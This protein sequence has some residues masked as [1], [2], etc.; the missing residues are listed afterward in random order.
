MKRKTS[1]YTPKYQRG[2]YQ[3]TKWNS[4]PTG[5]AGG[6]ITKI[7][8]HVQ[9]GDIVSAAANTDPVLTAFTFQLSDLDQVSTYADLYDMWRIDKIIMN[10]TPVYN[11]NP[12]VS[13]GALGAG[14]VTGGGLLF[15]AKDYTNGDSPTNAAEVIQYQ[16]VKW[17]PS[18]EAHWRSIKPQPFF[19]V[20]GVVQ[21]LVNNKN[22]W[23]STNDTTGTYA[24]IK[25]AYV[26]SPVSGVEQRFAVVTTYHLSFKNVK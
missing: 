5:Q 8:Q 11:C 21:P 4:A 12:P 16:T 2:K 13:S 9:F 18:Y 17:T 3:K 10:F 22:V 7:K 26:P 1:T 6:T 20:E 24:G 19:E 14:T 25:L 15:T 23:F